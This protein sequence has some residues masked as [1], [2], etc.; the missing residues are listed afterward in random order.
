MRLTFLH[1]TVSSRFTSLQHWA[2]KLYSSL[3]LRPPHAVSTLLPV[4]PRQSPPPQPTNTFA[5]INCLPFYLLSFW[6]SWPLKIE[7]IFCP[8]TSVKNRHSAPRNILDDCK[9][10]A[11]ELPI[12]NLFFLRRF[13]NCKYTHQDLYW[14]YNRTADVCLYCPL[15]KT[16]GKQQHLGAP[17]Y[18]I[19]V[20][21]S[22]NSRL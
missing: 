1:F 22:V 14:R 12:Y 4:I 9:C 16:C 20:W 11:Y 13:K 3:L 8:E 7:A 21:R 18:Q 19:A 5:Y 17:G 2:T 15:I 6:T 10:H